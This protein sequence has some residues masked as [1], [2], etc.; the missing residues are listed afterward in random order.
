MTVFWCGHQNQAGYGLSVAPQNHREG[1]DGAG[2]A[3]RSCSLLHL[4]ASRA[5]VFQSG[6]KTG[7][8]VVWMVQM[9]SS[10]RLR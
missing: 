5:R 4:E 10:W 1:E 7:G 8:G 6:I 3:S 9:T 2:H